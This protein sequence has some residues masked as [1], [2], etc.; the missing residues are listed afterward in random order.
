L[1]AAAEASQAELNRRQEVQVMGHTIAEALLEEGMAKGMAKGR[2]EGALLEARE[3]LRA[4][5]EERFG[6]L[7]EALRQRTEAATDLARLRA[8]C[9]QSVHLTKVDELVL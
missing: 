1:A 9:R 8:A 2:E 4:L 3:L 5:L 6:A 7:P